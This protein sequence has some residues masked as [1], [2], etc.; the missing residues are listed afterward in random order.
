MA[1]EIR[2]NPDRFNSDLEAELETAESTEQVM[3]LQ[4]KIKGMDADRPSLS[5]E[6]PKALVLSFIIAFVLC[7][8][9]EP[10]FLKMAFKRYMS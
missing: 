5:K 4:G 7:L 10:L 1:G 6:L 2:F 9:L 8:V 3:Q